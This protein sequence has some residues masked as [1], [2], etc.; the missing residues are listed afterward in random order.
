M[1]YFGKP[2]SS[3]QLFYWDGTK[4]LAGPY[5]ATTSVSIVSASSVFTA[6]IDSLMIDVAF[7]SSNV[8]IVL[9]TSTTVWPVYQ[10][11]Q[12]SKRHTTTASISV[13]GEGGGGITINGGTA[14]LSM[15]LP[16]SSIPCSS[17]SLDPA[18]QVFRRSATDFRIS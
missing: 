6:S 11:R 18:Y 12:I 17:A 9:P 13:I 4:F 3:P 16:G 8:S 15:S 2:S 7:S 14:N 1:S 10:I 5:D